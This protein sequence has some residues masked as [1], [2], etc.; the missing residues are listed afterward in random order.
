[1]RSS[2]FTVRLAAHAVLLAFAGMLLVAFGCS[3][4]QASA[5]MQVAT[6]SVS[7]AQFS[8]A[9]ETSVESLIAPVSTACIPGRDK[10]RLD[11]DT[12]PPTPAQL[13]PKQNDA[14]AGLSRRARENSGAVAL[15]GRIPASLT[16]LDLGIVR[17]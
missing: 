15:L 7:A 6:A 5:G 17:T 1:M 13:Q 10:V 2:S 8:P 14:D 4:A 12:L 9:I 16:H 3:G 11:R